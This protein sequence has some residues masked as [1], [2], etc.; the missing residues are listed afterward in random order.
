MN[1]KIVKVLVFTTSLLLSLGLSAA[2][3]GDEPP[4]QLSNS[5][6]A[7]I[8]PLSKGQQALF[9]GVLFSTTAAQQLQ[10][11]INA[12]PDRIKVEI[13]NTNRVAS[14]QCAYQLNDKTIKLQTDKTIINIQLQEKLKQIDFL[15]K[16]LVEAEKARPNTLL[17]SLLGAGIGSAVTVLLTFAVVSAVH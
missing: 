2:A 15:E 8:V 5:T 3:S 12:I 16:H 13:D 17:W 6:P 7:M 10:A 4:K 11:Q 9:A 14:A 1:L